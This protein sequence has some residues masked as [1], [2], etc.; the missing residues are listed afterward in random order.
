[1]RPQ[2]YEVRIR[3]LSEEEGGGFLAE[4]PQFPACMSDGETPQEALDHVYDAI[5]CWMEA[6]KEMGRAVPE[7]KRAAA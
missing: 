3:P 7:P 5:V 6:A 4:V 1:L 2:D